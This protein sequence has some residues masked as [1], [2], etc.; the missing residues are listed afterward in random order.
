MLAAVG[1][2]GLAAAAALAAC[3]GSHQVSLGAK[4]NGVTV[5]VSKGDTIRLKLNENPSTGY[6]WVMKFGHGLKVISS[7]YKQRANTQGLVGAGGTHTWT[8]EAIG[9]GNQTVSGVYT[10][11]GTPARITT[12]SFSAT[13]LVQ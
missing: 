4:D 7:E 1:L 3:C 9:S 8:I 12:A 5:T 10:P 13:V 11:P 2:A 6:H